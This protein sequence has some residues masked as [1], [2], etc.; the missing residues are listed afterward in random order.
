MCAC[1]CVCLC[2]CVCVRACV[3]VCVCVCTCVRACVCAR[4]RVR[5]C[6]ACVCICARVC[7][8][9][10][11]SVEFLLLYLVKLEFSTH[12]TFLWHSCEDFTNGI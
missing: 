11:P 1:A 10:V 2:V 4:G 9:F 6:M 8:H 3:C 7:I 5:L 12:S